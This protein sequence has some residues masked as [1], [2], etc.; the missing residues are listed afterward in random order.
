MN[1]YKKVGPTSYME[2]PNESFFTHESVLEVAGM[3]AP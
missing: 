2:G 1:I 3:K